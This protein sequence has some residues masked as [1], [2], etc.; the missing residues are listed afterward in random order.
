MNAP[1]PQGGSLRGAF[2]A[3]VAPEAASQAAA[4]L[5]IDLH[6]T[7]DSF[8]GRVDLYEHVLRGVARES[9]ILPGQVQ[10]F[11]DRGQRGDAHRALHTFKGL[12]GTVGW[13]DLAERAADAEKAV[14][15]DQPDAAQCLAALAAALQAGQPHVFALL[16]VLRPLAREQAAAS[17]ARSQQRSQPAAAESDAPAAPTTR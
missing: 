10:S 1:A 13:L 11:I 5:G 16:G 9:V 15:A 8:C 12:V 2:P 14:G 4:A 3:V 6:A 17:A 7:L